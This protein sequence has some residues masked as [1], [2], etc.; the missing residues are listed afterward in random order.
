MTLSCSVMCQSG[1]FQIQLWN[2]SFDVL[3]SFS[4]VQPIDC[5]LHCNVIH[6]LLKFLIDNREGRYCSKLRLG[7][8]PWRSLD[9]VPVI[10]PCTTLSLRK[11]EIH[12]VRSEGRFRL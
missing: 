8:R 5:N 9:V 12:L 10:Y 1:M 2:N 6:G 3:P 7:G 11:I 4:S